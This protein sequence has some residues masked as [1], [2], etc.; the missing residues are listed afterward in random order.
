M[1]NFGTFD[2]PVLA[3]RIAERILEM[4]REKQLKPGDKLP[5]ERELAVSMQVSRPSLREALRALALLKVV[6]IRHGSG[7]YI[8]GIAP[9]KTTEN[10]DLIMEI[11]ESNFLDVFE[12]RYI[13]ETQIIKLAAE[14]ITDEEIEALEEY[15]Q[16]CI[17]NKDNHVVFLSMD[18]ELH[19]MIA[20]F[21]G[22]P[23]LTRF[24]DIVANLQYG[25]QRRKELHS[26]LD[27]DATIQEHIEIIAA[28]KVRDPDRAS[29]AMIKHLLN[30]RDRLM[31]LF[32]DNQATVTE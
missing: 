32:E 8:T 10:L 9:D 30:G 12:A 15:H 17:A 18:T 26:A 13:V 14:R 3:E 20:R 4:I 31:S 2:N 29:E 22:N 24:T 16:Q 11:D 25:R 21:S 1:T 28:I 27:I 6:E 7:T 5:P 19:C 23:V